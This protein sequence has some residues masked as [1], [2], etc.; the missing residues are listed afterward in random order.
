MRLTKM[1]GLGNDFVLLSD[2]QLQI[3]DVNLN[4]LARSTC[5]R[6]TGI[7]ADGL[8]LAQPSHSADIK[9]RIFNSDGSEAEMCG[10]GIRCFALFAV[11][12]N[13]VPS[14]AFSVET[15]AGIMRPEIMGS[16]PH[17]AS[18]R[19][20]MGSPAF[21]C[22]K[23]PMQAKSTAFI[24]QPITLSGKSYHATAV[25]MGVPHL[26][27]HADSAPT[28]EELIRV[29]AFAQTSP[30]FPEGINVNFLYRDEKTRE[31]H[32]RTYERGCGITCACGTG[33][34]AAAVA[35]SEAGFIEKLGLRE[36]GVRINLMLGSLFIEMDDDGNVFMTGP[37]E[38]VFTTEMNAGDGRDAEGISDM[39]RTMSEWLG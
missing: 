6:R 32:M 12:N 30:T 37:A 29:G 26:I 14:P 18:V 28:R 24:N 34:C 20:N 11:K 19:V 10:N 23:I 13:L 2:M 7:G 31:F 25:L 17:S 1:H 33:T 5:S 35:L 21:N 15:L 27:I 8:I 4:T 3:S 9:M 16:T 36:R 22:D 39:V 38:E